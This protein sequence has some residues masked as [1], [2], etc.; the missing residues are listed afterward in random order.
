MPSASSIPY[1]EWRCGQAVQTNPAFTL[2][3]NMANFSCTGKIVE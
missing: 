3:E 2:E 1:K